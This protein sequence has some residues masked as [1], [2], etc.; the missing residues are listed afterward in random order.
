MK[1]QYQVGKST[2]FW[3][4]KQN[5]FLSNSTQLKFALQRLKPQIF[6]KKSSWNNLIATMECFVW[7]KFWYLCFSFHSTFMLI[8]YSHH[9]LHCYGNSFFRCFSLALGFFTSDTLFVYMDIFNRTRRNFYFILFYSAE[10]SM[11][12]NN[13]DGNDNSKDLKYLSF[14][15]LLTRN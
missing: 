10:K 8:N 3:N 11:N 9:C 14:K 15:D 2:K 4:W 1:Y 13:D 5:P 12:I 7:M 6:K